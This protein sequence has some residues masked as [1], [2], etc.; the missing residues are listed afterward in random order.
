MIHKL[1]ALYDK[2]YLSQ[3]RNSMLIYESPCIRWDIMIYPIKNIWL[4]SNFIQTNI[5]QTYQRKYWQVHYFKDE[6]HYESFVLSCYVYYVT[7]TG[8]MKRS[9][10]NTIL[11]FID[12]QQ[13]WYL[14][15]FVISF[16]D[17]DR[18]SLSLQFSICNQISWGRLQNLVHL[19]IFWRDAKVCIAFHLKQS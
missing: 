4:N 3:N 17:N 16:D 8:S 13:W 11:L 14:Y 7:G 9:K 5:M 6:I 2:L 18:L 1:K 12:F 19:Y 15:L 10:I